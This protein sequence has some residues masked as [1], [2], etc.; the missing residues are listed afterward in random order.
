MIVHL[1]LVPFKRRNSSAKHPIN[2]LGR[3][4]GREVGVTIVQSTRVRVCMYVK[5][6]T[7]ITSRVENLDGI[8][9]AVRDW[10]LCG[11]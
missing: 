4:K 2:Y 1:Q 11:G 7:G 5:D 9:P 6:Y 10:G 3:Y 8:G